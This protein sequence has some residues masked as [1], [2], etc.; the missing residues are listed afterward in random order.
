MRYRGR[1]MDYTNPG[2]TLTHILLMI[3]PTFLELDEKW[4]NLLLAAELNLNDGDET[5]CLQQLL[6]SKKLN[7]FNFDCIRFRELLKL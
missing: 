1:Y 7:Y 5:C 3:S 4:V 6:F 2:V